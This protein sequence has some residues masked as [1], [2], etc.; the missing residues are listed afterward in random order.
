M[1][2]I[3]LHVH[4]AY[5]DGLF[6]PASLCAL[7]VQKQIRLI[8]LCDHDT[9]EGLEPMA[10][11][12]AE[13][14]AS[15]KTLAMIAGIELSTGIDGRLH[16]L[17]YGVNAADPALQG[18]IARL[19][20]MRVTRGQEMVRALARLGMEIPPALLPNDDPSGN[21]IG[22]PHIARALIAMGAV[23]TVDQ[24][25][26]RYLG[27]GKPAY[28]ALTH[29]TAEQGIRLLS[30]AGAVP[31]LAH[32]M[33]LGLA[34]QHLEAMIQSL[35]GVGLRGVEVYHP[36]AD[37]NGIRA[38]EAIARRYGLLVT[39]GSDFHGDRGTRGKLGGLPSGWRSWEADI[40]ALQ[41]AIEQRW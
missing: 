9:T 19:R 20:E 27:E 37:R 30:A 25:F 32:P 1:N 13:Q 31:V 14:N 12:V 35:I 29:L 21:A 15:G 38:L 26:D 18:A 6:S 3:D 40:E 4:S 34:P 11:A 10:V 8:A 23:N 2:S 24:A 7:A 17:G 39:G 33:R 16:L 22:R 28:A 5:S 36:S 41:S